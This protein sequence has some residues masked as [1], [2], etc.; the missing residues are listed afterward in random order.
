MV[1][2]W[3]DPNVQSRPWVGELAKGSVTI[4][5]GGAVLGVVLVVIGIVFIAG[6]VAAPT[7]DISVTI[8]SNPP[9]SLFVEYRPTTGELTIRG[10]QQDARMVEFLVGLVLVVAGILIVRSGS[11]AL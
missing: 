7:S 10:T 4:A 5:A 11:P 9:L 6:A 1:A 8:N 2:W 3:P